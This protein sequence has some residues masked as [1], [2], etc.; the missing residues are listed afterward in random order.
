MSISAMRSCKI[1]DLVGASVW[2]CMYIQQQLQKV[3]VHQTFE[4]LH[5]LGAPYFFLHFFVFL[6]KSH[7]SVLV[8]RFA[9]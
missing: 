6:Q 9:K 5:V 3:Y 7:L 4:L 1:L 8:D 2:V